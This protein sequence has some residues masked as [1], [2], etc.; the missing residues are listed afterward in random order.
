MQLQFSKPSSDL[1]FDL[2]NLANPDLPL[3]I[4]ANNCIVE[5]IKQVAV[6]EASNFRNTSARLRGVQGSGF[7]DSVTLYYDRINIAS[8]IVSYASSYA[9]NNQ[10]VSFTARNVHEALAV[11]FD[12]YGVNLGT[13]DVVSTGIA[14]A[15]S[16]NYTATFTLTC[17]PESPAYYGSTATK[18]FRGLPV[19]D[20]S[21]TV[22]KLD[23][24]RFPIDPDQ[25]QLCVDLLTFGIDFTAYKNLLNVTS[26][27]LPNWD[28]LRSVLDQLGLPQ[29]AAPLNSN[30]VSDVPTTNLATANKLYD[31]VVVQTGIDEAGAKGIAYYHYNN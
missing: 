16:P 18:C 24:M 17:Q 21:I 1:V 20:T 26:A 13:K 10:F 7:T 30:T 23:V 4:N 11:M 6:N 5:S 25:S 19:L 29:Y 31:R 14:G 12:T 28:G 9:P 3:S 22:D 8:L 2:I 27:G 15:N